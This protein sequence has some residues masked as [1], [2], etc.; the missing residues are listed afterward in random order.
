M[1]IVTAGPED[2]PADLYDL[3]GFFDQLRETGPRR[4]ADR[5]GSAHDFLSRS[6]AFISAASS[7]LV[8]AV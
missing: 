4:A 8:G 2:L 6:S 1:L 5:V 7:A 3:P